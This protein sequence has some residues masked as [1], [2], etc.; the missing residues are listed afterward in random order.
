MKTTIRDITTGTRRIAGTDWPVST[1][2]TRET[3]KGRPVWVVTQGLC[4]GTADGATEHRTRKAALAE[5]G[6]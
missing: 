6:E 1:T 3:R 2:I 4:N 5:I